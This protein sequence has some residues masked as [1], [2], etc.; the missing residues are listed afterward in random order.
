MFAVRASHPLVPSFISLGA[1]QIVVA[2]DLSESLQLLRTKRISAACDQ[3]YK[4]TAFWVSGRL[5]WHADQPTSKRNTYGRCH[6]SF[7]EE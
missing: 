7:V 6:R 5:R 2:L 3:E 4:D 1:P